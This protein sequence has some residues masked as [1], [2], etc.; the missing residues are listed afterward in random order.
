MIGSTK[1]SGNN[2]DNSMRQSNILSTPSSKGD[3]LEGDSSGCFDGCLLGDAV[4]WRDGEDD[5][6]SEGCDDGCEDGCRD[7]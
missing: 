4:G 6:R 2:L 5:G 7:G 3:Q 1:D